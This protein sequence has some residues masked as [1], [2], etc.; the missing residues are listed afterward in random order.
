MSLFLMF[1]C[2]LLVGM[3]VGVIFMSW[4]VAAGDADREMAR[5]SRRVGAK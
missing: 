1:L 3:L 5:D 4:F 2:G